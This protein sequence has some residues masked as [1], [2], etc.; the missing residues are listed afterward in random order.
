MDDRKEGIIAYIGT[1]W[2]DIQ[3]MSE[4]EIR[5]LVIADIKLMNED[6]AAFTRENLDEIVEEAVRELEG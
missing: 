6:E 2:N 1:I 4:D 5:E 3:G